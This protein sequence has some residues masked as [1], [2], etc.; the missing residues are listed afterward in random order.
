L[1]ADR[2]ARQPTSSFNDA[3][4][5]AKGLTAA[6]DTLNAATVETRKTA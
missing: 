2:W 1:L 5:R 3:Y 4:L 6:A